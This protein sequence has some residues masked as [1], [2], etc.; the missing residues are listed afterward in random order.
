MARRAGLLSAALLVAPLR[1]GSLGLEDAEAEELPS[2]RERESIYAAIHDLEHDH[3]TGKI[4]EA[5]YESMRGELRARAVELL[6]REREGAAVVEES[7]APPRCP[8]C[9]AEVRATDHFC[10]HCGEA[11]ASGPQGEA[12]V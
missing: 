12:K 6:R 4:T 11:L 1:G 7:L 10:S 8:S 9:E 5:D 3:E 2:L